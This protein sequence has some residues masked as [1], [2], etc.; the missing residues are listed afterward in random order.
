MNGRERYDREIRAD[1][2]KEGDE[3]HLTFM[4]GDDYVTVTRA[5]V[6]KDAAGGSWVVLEANSPG[7]L[8]KD[9]VAASRKLWV[10]KR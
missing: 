9:E 10:K 7:G 2:L 6:Q 5:E 4:G 8:L 3:L 1:E